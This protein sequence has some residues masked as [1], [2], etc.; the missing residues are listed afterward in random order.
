MKCEHLKAMNR[1]LK[2]TILFW[3]K[4]QRPNCHFTSF[5]KSLRH[6][7][8][9]TSYHVFFVHLDFHPT[10][11]VFQINIAYGKHKGK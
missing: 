6:N 11:W 8:G 1:L 10:S 9:Y 3:S 4:D 5:G 2:H 7:I